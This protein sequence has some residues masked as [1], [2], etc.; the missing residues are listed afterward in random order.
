MW[1][2]EKIKTNTSRN[3]KVKSFRGG[4]PFVK[5]CK[6][7]TI[8]MIWPLQADLVANIFNI[9]LN[10]DRMK[11]SMKSELSIVPIRIRSKNRRSKPSAEEL[12]IIAKLGITCNGVK[13]DEKWNR[14]QTRDNVE[15]QPSTRRSWHEIS[16]RQGMARDLIRWRHDIS[17][18]VEWAEGERLGTRLMEQYF[19]HPYCAR[20]P[21]RDVMPLHAL[22]ARA[23][24]EMWRY[25]ALVGILISMHWFNSLKCSVTPYFLLIDHFLCR[26][27]TFFEKLKIC[28]VEVLFLF[29]LF[30]PRIIEFCYYCS[31]TV[32]AQVHLRGWV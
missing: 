29:Q 23:V 24:E 19:A 20:N 3:K 22:S 14:C 17:H 9:L 21:L 25:I 27:F 2:V 1:Y 15:R 10:I 8:L 13:H 30:C 18:Q 26:L 6:H 32:F 7:Y 28:D 12:A 4:R 11:M 5:Y 31:C 16:W